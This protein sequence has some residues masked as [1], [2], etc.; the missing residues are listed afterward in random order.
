MYT[1]KIIYSRRKFCKKQLFLYTLLKQRILG[2]SFVKNSVAKRI[3]AELSPE[4]QSATLK[5]E[6]WKAGM[7]LAYVLV[8][9]AIIS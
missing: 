2:T 1:T 6:L 7:T 3:F 9:V 8:V 4:T 5:F